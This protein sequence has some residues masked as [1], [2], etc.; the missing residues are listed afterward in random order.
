MRNRIANPPPKPLMIYDGD[1]DFCKK[2]IRRWQ[3][4]TCDAVDYLPFQDSLIAA[5]FLEIPREE[6]E[7]SV[8]L[9]EPDGEIFSGAEAVFR[10]LAKNPKRP[11]LFCKSSPIFAKFTEHTYNF[12]ARHRTFFSRFS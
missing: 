11:L 1:C 9:I 4:L 7:R 8:Q 6:F 10:A 3:K 2:W 5:R 12:V